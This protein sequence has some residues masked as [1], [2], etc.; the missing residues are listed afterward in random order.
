MKTDIQPLIPALRFPEFEEEWEITKYGD[1]YTFYSTNSFSREKLNYEDG[2]IRNLHY[3]DIHKSFATIFNLEKEIV[4]FINL[5]IDLSKIKEENYC[6]EGDLVIADASEDYSDIGKTIELSNLCGEKVLAGLHTFLARPTDQ[7]M[8]LGLAGYLLQSWNVRK[9]IMIIAQG[10]KVLGLSTKRLSKINLPIP[11]LPE[12][13]KIASFLTTI[14]NRIQAL[15]KKKSSLEQYKKGVMQKIFSQEIR[16]KDEDGKDFSEWKNRLFSEI[17]YEHKLKSTGKEEVHSVSV[18]KG[19]INQIEHLGRSFASKNTSHY[20]R[21]L[22]NDIIYTKSPTG[23]FP[24][25]IIKQNHIKEDVILSPLYGVFTPETKELGYILHVHFDSAINTSNYLSS[26]IQKGAKNT[27]NITNKTFL[28]KKLNLPVSLKEQ[29]KI[30]NFLF[31]LDNKIALVNEQIEKTKTYK[32]G[33][34][35]KM[36]V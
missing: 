31:A 32:K 25:G 14:D 10:T 28:S 7:T 20:N 17:L 16:F 13:R 29:S 4:P 33:L 11:S 27:I 12:Q 2:G 3:G 9:Q 26:I 18:H 23:N 22:P 6:K 19:V 15:E 8:A 34:L 1:I 30:A 21:A 35:Q 24:L 5:D 36:F